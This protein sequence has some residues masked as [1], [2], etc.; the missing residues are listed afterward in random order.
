MKN[1]FP[2]LL[3]L[4]LGSIA[5][6]V[7]AQVSGL[8]FRD[9]N[10]NATRQTVAPMVE[11]VV[12]G[13]LVN[14]YNA[15]EQ[16]IASFTTTA[17]GTYTIPASGVAYNGTVGSNTGFVPN[18]TQVRLEFVYPTASCSLSS[19]IDFASFG[20]VTNSTAARFVSG[21]ATNINF[22]VNSPVNYNNTAANNYLF[23]PFQANGNSTAGT[24]STSNNLLG[25]PYTNAFNLGSPAPN[26]TLTNV[27]TGTTYGLAYSKQAQ[28]MFEGAYLK[29]HTGL[30]GSTGQIF[31]I[32][33]LVTGTMASIDFFDMDKGIDG[34]AA[35]T[36]DNIP[37]R[38][39]GASP[40]YGSATSYNIAVAND[41]NGY[42]NEIITY[43]GSV[44]PLSGYPA[45]LGIVGTNTQRGIPNNIN[46]GSNDPAAYGQIGRVGLGDINISDDGTTL[47]VTNLYDRKI[48]QLTLNSATNPTA[49]TAVTAITIPNPPL[50]ST[51]ATIG[52][53]NFSLTYTGANNNTLFYDGTRGY[54][55]AFGTKFY[56]GKLYIGTVTTGERTGAVH[57]LDNNAGNPEY[58][59]M[60]TYVWEYNTNTN[61]FTAIPIIQEPLNF[62]RGVDGDSWNE[63]WGLWSN[64]FITFTDNFGYRNQNR[65]AAP[66]PALTDI[67][68]DES[69][70]MLLG[71]RDLNGDMGG[72]V[73][74]SLLTT[75]V[76]YHTVASGDL[77]K[78]GF[79]T[80][81]CT[82]SFERNA[83]DGSVATTGANNGQGPSNYNGNNGEFFWR[84]NI[85]N[86][87]ANT[88][89]G[90]YCGGGTPELTNHTN[91]TMGGLALLFGSQ[92]TSTTAMDPKDLFSGGTSKMNN[93]TGGNNNDY[94]IY[95][96][97]NLGDNSKANG[98]GDLELVTETAPIEIGNRVWNDLNGDGI[99]NANEVG[100]AGVVL[101]LTNADGTAVDSDPATAGVQ[102]TYVTTDANGNWTISS[103]TGT[104]GT[105]TNG[106]PTGVN[107]GVALLPNTNYIVKLNTAL[108]GNDWDP[109]LNNG[110]GGGRAGSNLAGLQLTLAKKV[111]NGAADYAD[112]D[113]VLVA[114]V[115]QVS[116]TTGQFGQNN[117]NIDFGFKPLASI[118]DRVFK[119]DNNNGIQDA[120]EPGVAGVSV[121]LYQNGANGIP[122]DGDD[123]VIASTVTDAFGNY[124]F[125]NLTP[126]TGATTGYN[127]GF[128]LPTN[129]QFSPQ[130][131]VQAI[132]TSDATN[133]TIAAGGST[134]ANGSDANS[135]TG[136]TGSFWLAPGEN[137]TGADAGITPT[138][139]TTILNSVG[140]RVWFDNGAGALA[141]NG[142]Q[143]A[144][145]P[146]I[147]GVT[148]TLFAADG[149]TVIATT[150]T[151]A[152][153]NYLFSGLPAGADY[154]IGIQPPSAGMIFSPNIG[155][156]T[157]LNSSTNSDVDATLTSANYGKT[158]LFNTGAAGNNITG[159]DAGMWPQAT[160]TA[161]LG[162]RVWNDLNADGLQ[163][164]DV[165]GLFTEPG[166]AG[167]TVNLFEDV[168]GDGTLTG[169]ELT[170]V[171]TMVTDAFGNY[172]FNNLVVTGT[173]RWQVGFVQPSG[174]INTTNDAGAN[175]NVDSDIAN[176]AT[177]RTASIRLKN[178]ER[179]MSVDAG[180][181]STAPGTLRLG[182]KVFRDNNSNGQQDA[183][184]AGVAG[185][186]VKLYQNGADGL[187][188]TP[189]DVL[190]GTTSSDV[191]GNYLFTNLTA[192][193]SAATNYNVQFS[194]IPAGFS[195][196]SQ[197]VGATATDSDANS[198]G[199]T[200]S[201]NLTADNLTIDA[202]IKQG[203]SSNKGS[204]GNQ[205]FTDINNNGI[206]DAG[207]VGV[208]GVVVELY[209]DANNDG[210][211]S[212]AE[213][214][215]V[216]T[217][218]TNGTGGYIFS[219][220]DAGNYQVGFSMLP[221]GYTLSGKDLGA[222]DTKDSDGNI[223]GAAVSGNTAISGKTYSNLVS[224]AQGED[225]LTVDLG[226]VPPTNTNS[227]GGNAWFDSNGNGL[228]TEPG[229]PGITVTLYNNAGVAIA[230]T[231][232]DASGN[233]LFSGLPDGAYS[234]GFSNYPAGFDYTI[235]DP[236][237]ATA[238]ASDAD[239]ATGKTV[240]VTVNSGNRN[241]RTLDAGFISTRGALGDK[242]FEDLDGDGVQ[243]ANE[244]GI[245]GV[246]VTL[247]A[248]DGTT[249]LSSAITDA[250]GGYLFAN[251]PLNTGYVLGY[252]TLPNGLGFTP[253][254]Q[255]G[256]PAL[257]SDVN[258][259]TGKTDV[260]TLTT[261]V[262]VN[263][264]VDAG[265]RSNPI[266]SV[267]N[268]VWDDINANGIQDA[269]E[270]G[271]P[272]V[273]A[274]LYNSANVAIGSAV[275]DANGLWLIT[276]VAP[277][278]G[279]YVIFTNKPA[280]NFTT[281]DN[282]G[283]GTGGVTDTDTDS[284]VN[285]GGQS[286]AFDVTANTVNVKIDA[287][288]TQTLILA[289]QYSSFTAEKVNTTSVLNFTVANAVIGNTY[290]IERSAT[291]TG[292]VSIGSITGTTS[293]SYTYTDIS[294]IQNAKNYYR[295]KQTNAQ[296]AI[297][298]SDIRIVKYTKETKV[299][300]YPIPSSAVLNITMSDNLLNQAIIISL[301]STTGQLVLSKNIAKASGTEQINVSTLSNGTYQLV[302]TQRNQTI[303][304]Q[305][306]VV[307]K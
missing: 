297:A 151:D 295:I 289:A 199:K 176:N 194:N 80:S 49:V 204:L 76:E 108:T 122:G 291:G 306:I 301:Y 61:S 20:G 124:K 142:V 271:I 63:S 66:I 119:D 96:G 128:T 240:N 144:G 218:R 182:D 89:A 172:V 262:P 200:G 33:N 58:T 126:T 186:T 166:L 7:Q 39:A 65:Y 48:Y 272:G 97:N 193:S 286:G 112:N 233:Y 177:D 174:Y 51:K 85:W 98:L 211:I 41:A 1:I 283:P 180:F 15:A 6:N 75:S 264:N 99:Q 299:E 77:L 259:A 161:S 195:F 231:T 54:Q 288:I 239:R 187:P 91:T 82:Y 261:S 275:T 281:Q 147:S 280:G 220:L 146:G 190:V 243:G 57:T 115:P 298:Y 156:T 133:T 2:L 183:F 282:G 250:N 81:T 158:Q 131:N 53:A 68:F 37:T 118:G 276:N 227:I 197:N 154:I 93:T 219:N 184:E 287:G 304:K 26:R 106:S 3:M 84:D 241:D 21:G 189:D 284:D 103:A 64:R 88:C 215:P 38:F 274:T 24:S 232:T 242:V 305:A 32:S 265:V 27:N 159:I 169:G 307:T 83:N 164:V 78:A 160:N 270:P 222:D 224:I 9:Y 86:G 226:I 209:L 216:Q 34:N 100:I 294:P 22:G 120:G 111:G 256:N 35:T 300:V 202:G 213:L 19:A 292:F 36:G 149:V 162:N 179:N 229:L 95:N 188:G 46:V 252:S 237:N 245:A 198:S 30:K 230:T 28:K 185:V 45:G 23:L 42:P 74:Y 141:G 72:G 150:V 127:V 130:T 266:A 273:V 60:W 87:F 268:R 302:L 290:S 52:A 223:L 25:F 13:M 205:V 123:V 228:K 207:E 121:T 303:S 214:T 79:N 277:G 236:A 101:E 153:G 104:D 107:Y 136:R 168:D 129:Y 278:T 4:L 17:A 12:Q 134:A 73:N 260:I 238:N 178:N 44:D 191:N 221:T 247:Y 155:G 92:E 206:Q 157:P 113:G 234:V 132:G 50:R 55:R 235:K 293:T 62:S 56:R 94:E 175:D 269:G 263:T 70:S 255:G 10:G 8:V 170:P 285:A 114:S 254:A 14:A 116:I 217:T 140:D 225:N 117:H 296:G 137:E 138:I 212:G 163:N 258:V 279:Y 246:T 171:R 29:R 43:L 181:V 196:T 244:P 90:S 18:G 249:V 11:P 203:T 201:I 40:A 148:V 47:Y 125:D 208:A 145:E 210:I 110:A 165:N 253:K 173:N 102:P 267:G 152:N 248:A 105:V 135:N 192:S 31:L 139:A 257:D 251:L 16:L 167:V 143:D 69:G 71:Y 5:T 109:T 59:D 67:E